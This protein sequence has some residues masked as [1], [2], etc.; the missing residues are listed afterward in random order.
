[1]VILDVVLQNEAVKKLKRNLSLAL[2]LA[3]PKMNSKENYSPLADSS[4][5]EKGMSKWQYVGIFAVVGLLMYAASRTVRTNGDPV[6]PDRQGSATAIYACAIAGVPMI[7]ILLSVMAFRPPIASLPVVELV[8][9]GIVFTAAFFDLL[10]PMLG[11]AWLEGA[12]LTL[13]VVILATSIQCTTCALQ[14][15]DYWKAVA[16]IPV[17]LGTSFVAW[18]SLAIVLSPF[19]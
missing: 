16:G 14:A 15:A 12:A 4:L 18:L 8:I 2:G 7:A 11:N 3:V 1:M 13:G 19:D 17:V 6:L 5:P 10:D 9:V